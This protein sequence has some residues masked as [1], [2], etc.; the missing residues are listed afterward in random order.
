MRI[1]PREG[2]G[3]TIISRYCWG[4]M[5]GGTFP[6]TERDEVRTRERR[7]RSK[8][9]QAGMCCLRVVS[10]RSTSKRWERSVY[11]LLAF[12]RGD[13]QPPPRVGQRTFVVLSLIISI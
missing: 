11:R 13:D 12:V 8:R 1:A 10:I 3:G 2:D 9:R 7:E 6:N 5:R 4:G